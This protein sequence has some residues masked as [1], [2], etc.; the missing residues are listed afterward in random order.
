M[1]VPAPRAWLLVPS[2]FSL[3]HNLSFAGCL[4]DGGSAILP[5]RDEVLVQVLDKALVCITS[6]TELSETFLKSMCGEVK[7]HDA[8]V[9]D[10]CCYEDGRAFIEALATQPLSSQ[11]S[12][13]ELQLP[14]TIAL[15]THEFA[16][17]LAQVYKVFLACKSASFNEQESYY[18]IMMNMRISYDKLPLLL[19]RFA[20]FTGL[21]RD[22]FTNLICS[23][24]NILL[25]QKTHKKLI[26]LAHKLLA[27]N[28]SFRSLSEV[29]RQLGLDTSQ[30]S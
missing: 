7:L 16:A 25:R 2:R 4:Q 8:L 3:G 5:S 22:M 18:N 29:F 23:E 9:A 21:R 13:A 27:K 11:D 12:D 6:P 28:S 19:E 26:H 20:K 1:A 10:V 30:S 24:Y 17:D 15:L 14:S